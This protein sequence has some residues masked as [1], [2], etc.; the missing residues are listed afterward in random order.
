MVEV[1][2]CCTMVET[3]WRTTPWGCSERGW[4]VGVLSTH[5]NE[6]TIQPTYTH[7]F[8]RIKGGKTNTTWMKLLRDDAIKWSTNWKNHTGSAPENH[9][10]I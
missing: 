1:C 6:I 10:V 5:T 8:F 4:T 9:V 2:S 7:I 3:M